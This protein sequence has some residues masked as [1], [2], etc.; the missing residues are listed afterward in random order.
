ML[1]KRGKQG[2][3][4][5]WEGVAGAAGGLGAGAGLVPGAAAGHRMR[6][7]QRQQR[8]ITQRCILLGLGQGSGMIRQQG[9]EECRQ[10][11]TP[12]HFS[13]QPEP[14]LKQKHT[15]HTLH[16]LHTPSHP[17]TPPKRPLN[18]PETT[19]KCTPY[20]TESAQVEL[21]SGPV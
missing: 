10:G 17:L 14:F 15:L 20:P 6:Q 9:G 3:Q 13:A 5:K 4:V 2:H 16:T 21:K 11:L 1:L 8:A 18:T 19:P 12:V 7:W